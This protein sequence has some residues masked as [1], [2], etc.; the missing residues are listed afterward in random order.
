MQ[1]QQLRVRG[2]HEPADAVQVADRRREAAVHAHELFVEEHVD[3]EN[4]EDVAGCFHI[5][6]SDRRLHSS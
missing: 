2:A 6:V 1:R 4:A 3:P 5:L